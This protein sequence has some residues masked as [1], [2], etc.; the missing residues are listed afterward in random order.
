MV[1]VVNA[2]RSYT[3]TKLNDDSTH[4]YIHTQRASNERERVELLSLSSFCERRFVRRCVWPSGHRA[5][6][7]E[8]SAAY[9]YS[10]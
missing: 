8:I 4:T 1:D 10:D 2:P 5:T 3:L 7:Y 6:T 9:Y